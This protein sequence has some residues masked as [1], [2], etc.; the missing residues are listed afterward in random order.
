[1][2]K[3]D[4]KLHIDG[5]GD[6]SSDSDFDNDERL[7]PSASHTHTEVTKVTESFADSAASMTAEAEDK[8]GKLF[9]C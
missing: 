3:I 8:P 6:D 7:H 5:G 9:E 2:E 4:D 1:M